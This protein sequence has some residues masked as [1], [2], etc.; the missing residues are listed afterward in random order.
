MDIVLQ[1]EREKKKAS[2]PSETEAEEKRP[3]ERRDEET[4]EY[5]DPFAETWAAKGKR[6][7]EGPSVGDGIGM[8][9]PVQTKEIGVKA[10]PTSG[11]SS[12]SRDGRV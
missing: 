6:A 8:R 2:G 11:R 1:F 3:R 10:V 5:R 4:I 7:S 9:C 12:K